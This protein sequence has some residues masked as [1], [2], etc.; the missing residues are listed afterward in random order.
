MPVIWATEILDNLVKKGRTT[1]AEISDAVKSVRAE[2]VMLNKGP[3]VSEG[4]RMLRDIDIRMAAHE[5]KKM[6]TLRSLHVAFNFL[7]QGGL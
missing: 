3:F 4:L 7:K 6:K 2:C 5:N 1:R